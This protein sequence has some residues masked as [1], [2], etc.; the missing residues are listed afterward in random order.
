MAGV[1]VKL[2]LLVLANI[3]AILLLIWPDLPIPIVGGILADRLFE[4]KKAIV[5]DAA[6][7]LLAIL[8]AAS[9]TAYHY[10]SD[11]CQILAL[12]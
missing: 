10:H 9:I 2:G 7:F 5:L 11:K 6:G 12:V 8:S 1:R 3:A 4:L